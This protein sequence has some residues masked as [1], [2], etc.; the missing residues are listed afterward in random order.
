M[1]DITLMI[2]ENKEGKLVIKA[3]SP[4]VSKTI[5]IELK[6]EELDVKVYND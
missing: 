5:L 4:L 1:K 3:I 2:K 6:G